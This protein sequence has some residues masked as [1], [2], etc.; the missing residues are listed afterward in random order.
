MKKIFA[1]VF[2]LAT[3]TSFGQNDQRRKDSMFLFAPTAKGEPDGELVSRMM[4]GD[5]GR[6]ISLDKKVELIIPPGALSSETTISIQPV[7]NLARGGIGKTYRFEPSGIQFLKSVQLIFHY[8]DK[9]T[10]GDSPQLLSISTQNE[11]GS[12]LRLE[13]IKVDTESKTVIGNT[14]H[15][16][17]FVVHWALVMWANSNGVK[18]G[19]KVDVQ[20]YITPTNIDI[21]DT[22]AEDRIKGH[23]EWFDYQLKNARNWSVN[24]IPDGNADVGKIVP[25]AV[26]GTSWQEMF[27]VVYEAPGK[28]PDQ[29]PVEIAVEVKGVEMDGGFINVTR[30]CKVRVYDDCYEVTMIATQKGG[31]MKAWGGI[32]K[33]RDEGTFVLLLDK[34]EPELIRIFNRVEDVTYT[35]CPDRI[36]L[37]PNTNTGIFHVEAPK[38]IKITP[39]NPPGQPN[40]IVEI[41]FVPYPIEVTRFKYNCPPPP[42]S[43]IKGRAKGK[44][45]LTTSPAGTPPPLMMLMGMPALPH[46]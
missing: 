22:K 15:F 13:K 8:S 40:R 2:L 33:Y 29:N 30:K 25:P 35:N 45:D 20:L 7:I 44:I 38:Q 18:V 42:G 5:G 3:M 36:I 21:L 12:W 4:N 28:L 43:N 26:P 27:A 1:F 17:D 6:L 37:N 24:G 14:L 16:S 19:K 41:W 31:S 34:K 10:N 11:K 9:E 32:M 23:N 39:A 46:Y